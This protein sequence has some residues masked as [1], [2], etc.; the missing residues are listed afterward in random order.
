MDGLLWFLRD[1][2]NTPP[3][4]RMPWSRTEA[5]TEW[6]LL[7]FPNQ[8][9]IG[10]SL[11]A[12][13]QGIFVETLNSMIELI[14]HRFSPCSAFFSLY[15]NSHRMVGWKKVAQNN[16]AK[17]G[18]RKISNTRHSIEEEGGV[19]GE[20]ER[21]REKKNKWVQPEPDVNQ[22]IFFL[23]SSTH[24]DAAGFSRSLALSTLGLFHVLYFQFF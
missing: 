21:K 9:P 5:E 19:G 14:I 24:L 12:T 13:P 4:F 20:I 10:E 8:M 18:I 15:Q 23:S 6:L 1:I 7:C 17:C 22:T 2:V 3:V 16:E 11:K